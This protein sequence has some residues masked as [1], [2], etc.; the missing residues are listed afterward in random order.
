MR[1]GEPCQDFSYVKHLKSGWTIAAVAD[2][3]GSAARAHEG[4]ETAVTTAVKFCADNFPSSADSDSLKA[5]LLLSFHRA[6]DTITTQARQESSPVE[7]FD[8]TLT[9]ALFRRGRLL[10]GHCGD[11]GIFAMNRYGELHEITQPQKGDDG[12]SVIPLRAGST[13]W[14]IV[15]Y[16]ETLAYILL[17]TDGLREKI[18]SNDLRA[19][20]AK[21]YVPLALLLGFISD[22]TGKE[23]DDFVSNLANTVSEAKIGESEWV[24]GRLGTIYASLGVEG[25]DG[26]VQEIRIN[27][28]LTRYLAAIEDDVSIAVICDSEIAVT[29]DMPPTYYADPDW[30]V[31]R[32]ETHRMLYPHL[33]EHDVVLGARARVGEVLSEDSEVGVTG[34]S[35]NGLNEEMVPAAVDA[36]A[37]HDDKDWLGV[38]SCSVATSGAIELQLIESE[39]SMDPR[40]IDYI[41]KG[42]GLDDYGER[43]DERGT[44]AWVR[45]L[46]KKR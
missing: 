3:V 23:L 35:L 11:G 32:Q 12:D 10:Y 31:I 45:K 5:L 1:G 7:A 40:V 16:P 21:M 20:P 36:L 6:F 33:Y 25:R 24:Y 38:K 39:V 22:C 43:A 41:S 9:L 30:F 34:A 2:G 18:A 28:E 13:R 4:A 19:H 37:S 27:N 14:E 8:T 44:S 29:S 15:E 46:F 17:A 26:I 42:S